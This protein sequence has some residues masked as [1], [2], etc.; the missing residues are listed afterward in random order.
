M[1]AGELTKRS[2]PA[3]PSQSERTDVLG[4]KLMN[5]AL[6]LEDDGQI[7]DDPA[8]VAERRAA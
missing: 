7:S 5:G 4:V 2:L 1:S 3:L 6:F 8:Y